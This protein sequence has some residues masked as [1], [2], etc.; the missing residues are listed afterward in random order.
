[1][2]SV[3]VIAIGCALAGFALILYGFI[4]SL[5]DW[6]TKREITTKVRGLAAQPGPPAAADGGGGLGAQAGQQGAP[7]QGSADFVKALAELSGSL[8]KLSP[9]IGS[10]IIA[11]ILF[12]LAVAAVT[13]DH[14][15]TAAAGVAAPS[16]KP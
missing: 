11:T 5:P 7:L 9:A 8:A 13:A 4:V 6:Q 15:T 3:S 10:F 2:S 12:F 14:V 16:P 1:M